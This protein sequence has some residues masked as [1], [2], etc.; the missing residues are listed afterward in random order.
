MGIVGL[1]AATLL[2]FPDGFP[3]GHVL[4]AV[5]AGEG[6]GLVWRVRDRPTLAAGVLTPA[7]WA[8]APRSVADA[9]DDA[10]RG[11]WVDGGRVEVALRLDGHITVSDDTCTID[12]DSLAVWR[13]DGALRWLDHAGNV[14]ACGRPTERPTSALSLD[15]VDRSAA[16]VLPRD[17][18]AVSVI[19]APDGSLEPS[20]PR[21]ARAVRIGGFY[22]LAPGVRRLD[23]WRTHPDEVS[24]VVAGSTSTVHL[25]TR[26]GRVGLDLIGGSGEAWVRVG[27]YLNQLLD[28]VP[29][30]NGET[31]VRWVTGTGL[32]FRVGDNGTRA[33]ALSLGEHVTHAAGVLV[34]PRGWPPV[35]LVGLLFPLIWIG[36]SIVDRASGRGSRAATLVLGA[37][38]VVLL[39]TFPALVR[40]LG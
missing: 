14:G 10:L 23:R 19:L 22:E 39:L 29:V 13:T 17:P 24:S 31:G 5:P 35:L 1:E 21:A 38:V 16:G 27:P 36:C 4:G 8:G 12:P 18:N 32:A 37:S 11:V 26:A 33:D 2:P 3:L 7:G 6:M 30:A 34:R 15:S 20:A 40:V 25:E 28:A 9:P